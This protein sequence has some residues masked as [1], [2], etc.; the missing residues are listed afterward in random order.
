MKPS[1]GY[2]ELPGLV[3]SREHTHETACSA[4][5]V[6]RC[7]GGDRERERERDRGRG[8]GR[9]CVSVGEGVG[10]GGKVTI[11][12]DNKKCSVISLLL[13]QH[14]GKRRTRDEV[15]FVTSS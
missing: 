15:Y 2:H 13:F 6:V 1:P 4:C 3:P 10:G 5:M 12:K 8:G 9:Q 11:K 7:V 14:T